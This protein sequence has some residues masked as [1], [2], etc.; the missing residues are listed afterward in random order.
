MGGETRGCEYAVPDPS[1]E[2]KV[3][4]GDLASDT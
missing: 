2:A 1:E 3:G 4:N